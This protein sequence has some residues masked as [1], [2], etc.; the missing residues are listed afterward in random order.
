M[1][2]LFQFPSFEDWCNNK[3]RFKEKIGEF[4]CAFEPT[5]WYMNSS[6]TRYECSI[7]CS[8]VPNNIYVHKVV[9]WSFECDSTDKELVETR[10]I[11]AI[12]EVHAR[13]I[14]Y[15]E[16]NYATSNGAFH[17]EFL[18]LQSILVAAFCASNKK[19]ISLDEINQLLK[20]IDEAIY[21]NDA[22]KLFVDAPMNVDSE[23][24]DQIVI[25][26]YAYFRLCRNR[27]GI[28]LTAD[29]NPTQ[30]Y[31]QWEI[32]NNTILDVIK[33]FY[34]SVNLD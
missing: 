1:V 14:N 8:E 23:Y 18:S 29:A 7:A 34:E 28:K 19:E 9:H 4:T 33:D 22:V 30:L 26:G 13:W 12:R 10:Y 15:I 11:E 17:P 31:F 32:K 25:H 20:K 6:T 27:T 24:L 5:C 2:K 3:R 16:S 21:T